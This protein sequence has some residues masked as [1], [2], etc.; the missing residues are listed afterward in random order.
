MEFAQAATV[1]QPLKTGYA[2]LLLIQFALLFVE[3]GLW[4]MES[5]AMMGT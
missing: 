5:N 3:M 2:Q 1:V 4:M